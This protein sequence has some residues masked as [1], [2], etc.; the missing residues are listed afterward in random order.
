MLSEKNSTTEKEGAPEAG[1]R[2]PAAAPKPV[3]MAQNIVLTLKVLAGVAVFV[4][5]IWFLDRLALGR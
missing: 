3:G 4:L 5:L 2:T 1:K